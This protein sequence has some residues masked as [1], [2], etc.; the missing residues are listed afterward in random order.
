MPG[1]EVD[2]IKE[3]LDLVGLLRSYLTL[4]PA[5]KNFRGLCPFHGEKT[6]SFIVSPER[7]GWHCFGCGEGGDLIS[8]VMKYEHLEFPEALRF[9]AERAGVELARLNPQMEREFG[10]LYSLHDAAAEFYHAELARNEPA[11]A[12][13][14]GRTLTDETIREFSLGF[15]PLGE[16][17]TLHL[18]KLGHAIEDVVRAGLA[19]KLASGL[20]RDRFQNR[21]VFPI[22]NHVGK[23]VAFTG[24]VLPAVSSSNPPGGPDN[25][26]IPKYLNSPETPIFNKS[27]VLFGLNHSKGA[28]AES[29]TVVLVE[30]QMDLLSVWQ[31][32]VKNVVAVS[33]TGLSREHLERLRRLA[34]TMLVSFDNDAAGVKALERSFDVLNPFDF[35]LKAIDLGSY[36]DPGEACEKDPAFFQRAV[37]EARPAFERFITTIVGGTNDDLAARKRATRVVLEKVRRLK[38][39]AEQEAWLKELSKTAGISEVSL[40]KEL[41]DLGTAPGETASSEPAS[42]APGVPKRV[43][44]IAERLVVLAFTRKEFFDKVKGIA[45]LLPSASRV[46]V[47]H[48]DSAEAGFL[49]MQSGVLAGGDARVLEEEFEALM[50]ALRLEHLKSRQSALEVLRKQA[51]AHG[52]ET[53]ANELLMEYTKV[54]RELDDLRNKKPATGIQQ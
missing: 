34:D 41:E 47:E 53:E 7:K 1:K 36:K 13:L 23:T 25:P 46:I 45:D 40:T 38:S 4:L 17:L 44:M 33:G 37:S 35:H 11:R 18:V 30:G 49:E 19:T 8:F 42:P 31:S 48:P 50:R 15:A 3:R 32:G 28:I 5:G 52:K 20:H 10:I 51:T 39:A 21:I 14:A 43:D 2:L 6:P 27:K 9:L 12:Y 29:R 26:D 54:S 16:K 22:Q 24:R